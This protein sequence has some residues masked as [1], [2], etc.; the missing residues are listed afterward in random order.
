MPKK[1][2]L[3]LSLP[4]CLG[5]K[6]AALNELKQL[7]KEKEQSLSEKRKASGKQV[8]G[9]EAVKRQL[10]DATPCSKDKS[11]NISPRLACRD[12]WRKIEILQLMK[13]FFNAYK[14]AW[15]QYKA[16]EVG[17]QFPLGSYKM[18]LIKHAVIA[19]SDC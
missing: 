16:G 19:E 3:R 13:S 15:E 10:I 1:T 18:G 8:L 14:Q 9:K 6:R 17:V 4:A 11:S 7:L 12:K 5:N 2:K